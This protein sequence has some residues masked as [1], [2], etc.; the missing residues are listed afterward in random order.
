MLEN[1]TPQQWGQQ[2][3]LAVGA[4]KAYCQLPKMSAAA[5]LAIAANARPCDAGVQQT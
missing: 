2:H 1:R 3:S 4:T 5:L